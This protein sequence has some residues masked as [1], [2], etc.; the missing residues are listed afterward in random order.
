MKPKINRI[1]TVFLVAT[2]LTALIAVPLLLWKGMLHWGTW[3]LF[4]VMASLI[5][6][7]I[8]AGYHRLFSHRSYEASFPVRLFFLLFGAAAFE[9]SVVHWCSDHRDHHQHVDHQNDP[10]N[11][12]K[13]FFHAHMGWIFYKKPE[14]HTIRNIPD[15]LKDPLVRLQDRFYYLIAVLIGF[16]LPT[17]VAALWGDPWGGFFLAGVGRVVFNHHST[18]LI[19]SLCHSIGK[20]PYSDKNSSKDS[21]LT[22]VLTYGEGYH[23]FHHAFQADY[24]NGF[25][26]WHW[27]PTKWLIN[28]L[29]WVGLAENLR[30]I[31]KEKILF[32]KLRMQE[33]QLL[34]KAV[35]QPAVQKW[36]EM[37]TSARRK[38][39]EAYLQFR[40]IKNE[41][42]RLKK[43]KVSAMQDRLLK[44]KWEVRK[45]KV[46]MRE[47]KAHWFRL[48]R[49]LLSDN[50]FAAS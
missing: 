28:L 21:W 17:A 2:P 48:Y 44:L 8:T 46:A 45:R 41:Y 37:V 19:N 6:L 24:R 32:A 33:K 1:N 39:E 49:S 27:D 40:A 29:R 43:E 10:Y 4:G 26:G 30:R 36:E 5:G 50:R 47:A 18:F 12:Q 13:G 9:N 11:I 25:R 16:G 7:S 31:P 15:L 14:G 23:N 34:E 20:Q 42:Y 3:V 38:F 22:A 35:N